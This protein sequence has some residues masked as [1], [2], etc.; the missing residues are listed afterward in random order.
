MN[1]S[2]DFIIFEMTKHNNINLENIQKDVTKLQ[3]IF[4]IVHRVTK[5]NDLVGIDTFALLFSAMEIAENIQI[6]IDLIKADCKTIYTPIK[7]QLPTIE[8]WDY[9]NDEGWNYETV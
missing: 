2:E 5:W 1:T 7:K 3:N 4:K 6:G 9:K 8:G